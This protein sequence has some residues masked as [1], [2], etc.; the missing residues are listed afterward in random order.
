MSVAYDKFPPDERDNIDFASLSNIP[1]IAIPNASNTELVDYHMQSASFVDENA[2]SKKN[3]IICLISE[4]IHSFI[5][6]IFSDFLFF[7]S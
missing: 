6:S 3:I 2:Y 7:I 4:S 1:N 5:T